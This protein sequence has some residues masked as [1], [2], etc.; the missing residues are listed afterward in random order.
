MV[1]IILGSE[2]LKVFSV[3]VEEVEV[4]NSFLWFLLF[5]LGC[6]STIPDF[7]LENSHRLPIPWEFD[8]IE[9]IVP[10]VYLEG[11]DWLF[12]IIFFDF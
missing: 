11:V 1:P 6:S 2:R 7:F 5:F 3:S 9:S 4:C 8:E 12:L 10:E